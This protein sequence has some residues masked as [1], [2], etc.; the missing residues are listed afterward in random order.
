[1]S[2]KRD[3]ASGKLY[4][5]W[6]DC[7]PV[8]R[9]RALDRRWAR[10][11]L[12]LAESSDDGATWENHKVIE[13]APDHGYCYIAMYFNGDL[14]HLAYCCGGEPDCTSTLHETKINTINI[15]DI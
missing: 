12:V 3:P 6:N 10:T 7:N 8:R 2:M 1:M 11:P 9:V 4:A 5:V 13:D 14:L 15:R